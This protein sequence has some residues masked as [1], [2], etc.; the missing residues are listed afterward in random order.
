MKLAGTS[1]A[2]WVPIDLADVAKAIAALRSSISV[3]RERARQAQEQ[4]AQSA[5]RRRR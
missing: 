4:E 1:D 2:G 5:V 3:S